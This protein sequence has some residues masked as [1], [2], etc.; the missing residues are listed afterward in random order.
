MCD[1]SLTSMLPAITVKQFGL[2]RGPAV[3]SVMYS[4]FGVSSL[5]GF[6]LVELGAIDKIG[7]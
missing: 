2:E 7:Y 3:Y 4:V 1:G 6:G 5:L